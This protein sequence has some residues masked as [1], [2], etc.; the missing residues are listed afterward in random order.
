MTT[1]SDLRPA[2][3]YPD[4][5]GKHQHRWWDGAR[6]TEQVGDAGAAGVDPPLPPAPPVSPS[7]APRRSNNGAFVAVAVVIAVIAAVVAA[8]ALLGGGDDGPASEGGGGRGDSL[9]GAYVVEGTNP[10]GTGYRGTAEITGDDPDYRIS[11][12]TGGST[13]EGEG[14]LRGT[15]FEVTYTGA[16][17]GTGSATY[18]LRDDGT[19]VGTWTSGG[20]A[21]TE[22]LIPE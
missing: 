12:V 13:S 6:W 17:T 2:G 20:A 1:T 4:P 14:T 7:P 5:S 10:N 9:A 18:E 19:L 8:F 22:T 11:W 3:W 16:L 15:T 21:G